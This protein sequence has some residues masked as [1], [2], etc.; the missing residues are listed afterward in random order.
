MRI[1]FITMVMMAISI[2][3]CKQDAS[4]KTIALK[5]SDESYTLVKKGEGPAPKD[6]DFSIFS[7]LV[8]GDD[9]TVLLDRTD[10]SIWAKFK[11]HSD[12]SKF[13]QSSPVDEMLSYLAQGDS[14]I[15]VYE[16]D[17]LEK[18]N[19]VVA[20]INKITYQ[21]SIKEVLTEEEMEQKDAEEQ[22]E[23]E[24]DRN[25]AKE[26]EAT[27]AARV[28]EILEGFKNGTLEGVQTTESGLQ[29]V[30]EKQG[31]GEVPKVSE[32]VNVHYYGV[33]ESDGSMFDNSYKRG[34]LFSFPV[35]QGRV[36]QGWDEALLLM[37]KGTEAVFFI[38]FELAYGA[39]GRPPRIPEKANLVF[40]IEYPE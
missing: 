12:S 18:M 8:E 4:Q 17:S 33:L 25:I 10:E 9:G 15:L 6:G 30:I 27:V 21:V 34:D 39:A 37:P 26:K 23:K 35:G 32:L 11:V 22:K 1:L 13:R 16:L 40:F 29:Y 38:P 36:I 28:A 7:I 3:A 19:P 5:Y 24:A 20:N 2:A 14:A 31:E